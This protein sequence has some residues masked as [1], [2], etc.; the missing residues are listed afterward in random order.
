MIQYLVK[1]YDTVSCILQQ[2]TEPNPFS[3]FLYSNRSKT[4]FQLLHLKLYHI[5][6]NTKT[7]IF[8]IKTNG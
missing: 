8:R 2:N 5:S 7:V 1:G 4:Y 3:V 6:N